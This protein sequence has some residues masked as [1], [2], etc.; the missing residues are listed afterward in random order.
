M[1][2]RLGST[3]IGHLA[4]SPPSILC[5]SQ[6][7]RQRNDLGSF[8]QA[9]VSERGTPHGIERER[10]RERE[11]KRKKKRMKA[12]KSDFWPLLEVLR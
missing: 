5:R 6:S 9:L 12:L 11:R 4:S 1:V 10:E 2:F 7:E 3:K 8:F